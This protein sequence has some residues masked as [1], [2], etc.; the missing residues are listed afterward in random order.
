MT[1]PLIPSTLECWL[2]LQWLRHPRPRLLVL[3]AARASR[4]RAWR[5]CQRNARPAIQAV[6]A[7]F[8]GAMTARGDHRER[9]E[10]QRSA[11]NTFRQ[12]GHPA[13]GE[14]L[15]AEPG[16]Q[17]QQ[18]RNGT[19][20][21]RRPQAH[22][23]LG[24][25]ANVPVG[26]SLFTLGLLLKLGA[27]MGLLSRVLVPRS[28]RRGCFLIRCADRYKD[29]LAAPAA[30]PGGPASDAGSTPRGPINSGDRDQY[31]YFAGAAGVAM[32]II[33]ATIPVRCHPWRP[34]WLRRLLAPWTHGRPQR[35]VCH[36]APRRCCGRRTSSGLRSEMRAAPSRRIVRATSRESISAARSTPRSPP[37]MSPNR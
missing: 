26:M 4:R 32:A 28:V 9:P 36:S 2:W 14:Q 37:A 7:G 33:G 23:T 16:Q 29:P 10:R 20:R 22:G 6:P 18:H 31:S 34:R 21:H 11:K 3:L 8:P 24:S 30:G 12:A 15:H 1:G 5:R 25:A 35:W 13:A 19:R 17:G 27:G